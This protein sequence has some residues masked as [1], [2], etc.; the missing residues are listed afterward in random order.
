MVRSFWQD[1][2]TRLRGTIVESDFGNDDI[3]FDDPDSISIDRCRLTPVSSEELNDRRTGASVDSLLQTPI[4]ADIRMF[5]RIELH[6][7][8]YDVVL[9]PERWRGVTGAVAHLNVDL[10]EVLS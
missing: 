2:V 7:R 1:T 6:G 5:D 4:D 9:P 8:T 3:D 10:R